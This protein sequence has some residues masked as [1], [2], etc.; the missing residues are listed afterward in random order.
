MQV[1]TAPS[2]KEK[3]KWSQYPP[4]HVRR[5]KHR[6]VLEAERAAVK[7]LDKRLKEAQSKREYSLAQVALRKNAYV[8]LE[9]EVENGEYVAPNAQ[10]KHM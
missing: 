2:V 7:Q 9:S 4:R 10:L 3:S 1:V 5:K 6:A 8:K